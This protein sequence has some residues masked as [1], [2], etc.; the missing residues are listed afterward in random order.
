MILYINACVRPESRTKRLADHVLAS[1]EGPVKEIR[2]EE[3]SFPKVDAAFIEKRNALCAE[4]DFSDPIFDPAKE[5]AAADTILVAAPFYDLSFPAMLKQYFEQ[6][7]VVGLT[8]FYN[9][10]N[11]PV[12]L[13]NAKKLYYVTT[14]GGPIFNDT[15]GFGYIT[16]LAHTFYGI[17]ETVQVKAENLD[18]V[19]NDPELILSE[20]MKK[21]DAGN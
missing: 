16:E 1:L 21:Y 9:E 11:I 4:R 15:Y 3:M 20:A 10:E 14:A 5:F 18:I 17:P 8:F 13:C 19:G 7:C 2:L 12:G 6:I